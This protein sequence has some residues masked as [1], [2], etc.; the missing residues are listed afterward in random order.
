M[1]PNIN[2]HGIYALLELTKKSSFIFKARYFVTQISCIEFAPRKHIDEDLQ[3]IRAL[4]EEEERDNIGSMAATE[5]IL[6]II[7][8]A[9]SERDRQR[10]SGNSI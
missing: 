5:K 10:S 2:N 6:S 3:T 9:E 4:V 7:R 1:D 8:K